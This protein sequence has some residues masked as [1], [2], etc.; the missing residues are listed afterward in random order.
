MNWEAIVY[1][2][3]R[4]HNQFPIAEKLKKKTHRKHKLIK[5]HEQK[6]KP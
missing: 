4:S 2:S 1:G 6:E 3:L 5:T